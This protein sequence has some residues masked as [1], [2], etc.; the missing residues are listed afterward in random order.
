MILSN[1]K[2]IISLN[3]HAKLAVYNKSNLALIKTINEPNVKL[4]QVFR[5]VILFNNDLG[6]FLYN[7]QKDT[8]T[9]V[10]LGSSKVTSLF[11]KDS[12]AYVGYD[13]GN[14]CVYNFNDHMAKSTKTYKH[15]GPVTS[16]VSDNIKIFVTDLRNKTTVYPENISYDFMEPRLFY[17]KFPYTLSDNKL[18]AHVQETTGFLFEFSSKTEKIQFGPAGGTIFGLSNDFVSIYDT[19]GNPLGK[20]MASD[21]TVIERNGKCF[22]IED[23]G[24]ILTSQETF[25]RD[26]EAPDFNFPKIEIKKKILT[27]NEYEEKYV[28]VD[29]G[30]KKNLSKKV[31]KKRNFENN[32][33]SSEHATRKGSK[34]QTLISESTE[35]EQ[36]NYSASDCNNFNHNTG[37]VMNSHS[38]FFNPV[39]VSRNPSSYENTEGR[40][41]YYSHQGFMVSLESAIS[42]QIFVKFHD[43]SYESYEIKDPLKC[44][45]GAFIGE[46]YVISDGET[47]NFSGQWTK[48]IKCSLLGMNQNCIYAFDQNI[49]TV[50]NYSGDV[51]ESYYIKESYSFCAGES[52]LAV[53]CKDFIMLIGHDNTSYIPCTGIEFGCFDSDEL[54]VKIG[55]KL[56]T[57]SKNLLKVVCELNERPL[58]VYDNNVVVL[59]EN[60]ILPRPIVKF[61]PI[62]IE[63]PDEVKFDFSNVGR[64]NPSN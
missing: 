35:S 5:D 16:M 64:Y 10:A 50:L 18:Y 36:T 37:N 62:R 8:K 48:S 4:F 1:E 13:N 14:I 44:K 31:I 28:Y 38:A 58:T 52:E 24:G 45:L 47:I 27:E 33:E 57:L 29:D 54:F 21:Y 63:V 30:N 61:Y 60:V 2:Y 19:L 55:S 6:V 43:R 12:F 32:S 49:L 22:I 9:E 3:K 39:L 41:L 20:F 25:V 59:A 53:F 23:N 17:K 26:L 42:N 11:I 40:L 15:P 7:I 34:R 46:N 51:K 56:F